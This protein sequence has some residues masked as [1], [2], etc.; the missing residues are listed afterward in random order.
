MITS[1]LADV[2]FG[3]A[4]DDDITAGGGNDTIF[5][6]GADDDSIDG[7]DGND[8]INGGTGRDDLTGGKG[9]DIFKYYLANESTVAGFDRIRDFNASEGDKI[10][11]SLIDAS[12]V[13]GDNNAFV[14]STSFTGM[15]GQ[16]IVVAVSVDLYH[17]RG[18]RITETV[19]RIFRSKSNQGRP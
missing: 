14:F 10:D 19:S 2:I 3:Q 7:G 15:A 13:V 12:T 4:G 1:Q 11:L 6:G 9:A 8:T 16:L 5:G 17:V 18:V